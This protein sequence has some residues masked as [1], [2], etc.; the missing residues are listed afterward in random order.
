MCAN[1]LKKFIHNGS[2][3]LEDTDSLKN[4][5]SKSQDTVSL[6]LIDIRLELFFFMLCLLKGQNVL[7]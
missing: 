1:S 6:G 2:R 4:L 7:L 3:G 5:E